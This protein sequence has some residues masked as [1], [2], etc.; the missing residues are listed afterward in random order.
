MN[1]DQAIDTGVLVIGGRGAALRAAVAAHDAGA[2][3]IGVLEGKP[4][5]PTSTPPTTCCR[6][7][8]L[9]LKRSLIAIELAAFLQTKRAEILDLVERAEQLARALQA[10]PP[11]WVVCHSDLYAGNILLGPQV[12][13]PRHDGAPHTAI[14]SLS[15][16]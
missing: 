8:V 12:G 4:R 7:G 10:Q 6:R 16:Q 2:R 11:A 15:D 13:L 5:C 14:A 1:I 9:P 3:V